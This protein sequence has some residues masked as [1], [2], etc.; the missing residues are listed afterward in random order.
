MKKH[1][2]R[3]VP[4]L[5][6]KAAERDD[7]ALV[8]IYSDIRPRIERIAAFNLGS[9]VEATELAGDVLP[10]VLA[11]MPS[12]TRAAPSVAAYAMA[13]AWPI[14]RKVN[15][16]ALPS[17]EYQLPAHYLD[18]AES[19]VIETATSG[20]PVLTSMRQLPPLWQ[21][22]LQLRL[23]GGLS[24]E[25]TAYVL[26]RKPDPLRQLQLRALG[27]LSEWIDQ[28]DAGRGTPDGAGDGT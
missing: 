8:E 19:R 16:A 5:A 3:P 1:G 15:R 9:E 13:V 21:E 14:I 17:G 25:E 12:F 28:L 20:D 27:A 10:R 4:P 2:S 24:I 6:A 18:E 22:L 7:A 26:Q 23:L 11:A